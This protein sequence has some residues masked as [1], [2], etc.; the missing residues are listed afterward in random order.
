MR[1]VFFG[2]AALSL[3]GAAGCSKS[4][5][6]SKATIEEV[7]KSGQFKDYDERYKGAVEKLGQPTKTEGDKVIWI[8]KDGSKCTEFYIQKYP[9]G[10]AGAGKET[11]DCN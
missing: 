8:A 11:K 7:Y 4:G 2:I 10:K 6:L 9:G 5:G 1:T 3:I